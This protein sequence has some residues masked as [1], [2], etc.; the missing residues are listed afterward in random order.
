MRRYWFGGFVV[1][2]AVALVAIV[3]TTRSTD[4]DTNRSET[5]ANESA[6]TAA[7]PPAL[8]T[9]VPV[10]AG[11]NGIALDPGTRRVYTAD[12]A[13]NTVS[14]IDADAMVRVSTISIPGRPQGI[15]TDSGMVYVVI[16]DSGVVLKIDAATEEIVGEFAVEPN[17]FD[18]KVDPG[19][20][21]L[22]VSNQNENTVTVLDD[23]GRFLTALPV[24]ENP[25]VVQVDP[26]GGTIYVGNKD[27]NT[28]SVIDT[29]TNTVSGTIETGEEPNGIAVD[30]ATGFVANR[31]AGTVTVFDTT[32]NTKITD[33]EVGHEPFGVAVDSSSQ[34]VYV[35][36]TSQTPGGANAAD[37]WV[38]TLTTAAGHRVTGTFNFADGVPIG[39]IVDP[40]THRAFITDGEDGEICV[41]AR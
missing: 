38:S 20:G 40:V 15:A 24:G 28:V 26:A 3:L 1:L 36:N 12:T 7:N 22:Y 21:A 27:A 6:S 35:T 41:V 5:A 8:L 14:V 31:A 29:A 23:S 37:E 19:T 33:V 13:D 9:T 10:G 18:V 25:L 32:T 4:D 39:V 34:T 2:L 30:G 17:S 11:A 16:P